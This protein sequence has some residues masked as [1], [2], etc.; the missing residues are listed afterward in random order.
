MNRADSEKAPPATSGRII[1]EVMNGPEDGREIICEGFPISI[2]RSDENSVSLHCDH[3]VSR[4]H[5]RIVLSQS[6]LLLH[7]LDSTNGT[8]VGKSKVGENAPIEIDT[9]FR[10]GG[11]LLRI[12]PQPA[13]EPP[14]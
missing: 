7:D 2:G 5:A 6:G 14:E 13:E 11:T 8:F 10:V 4:K 3:L 12:L 9:L 1:V